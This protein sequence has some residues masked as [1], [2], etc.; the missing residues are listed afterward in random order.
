MYKRKKN[1]SELIQC[2]F[3][4]F[5][6]YDVCRTVVKFMF[7]KNVEYIIII[8]IN[9]FDLILTQVPLKGVIRLRNKQ[10]KINLNDYKIKCSLHE[11]S[12]VWTANIIYV[13]IYFRNNL[14][15]IICYYSNWYF[16]FGLRGTNIICCIKC[17]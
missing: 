5:L 2:I 17:R 11:I 7:I 1:N 8:D 10:T 16:H 13:D 3:Y 12:V 9:T 6:K 14:I 4:N 15:I